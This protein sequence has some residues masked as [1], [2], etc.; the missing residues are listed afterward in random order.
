MRGFGGTGCQVIGEQVH[1]ETAED[2]R[3]C[4]EQPGS[5]ASW[6]QTTAAAGSMTASVLPVHNEG[7]L[8]YS[9]STGNATEATPSEEAL[10]WVRNDSRLRRRGW[11]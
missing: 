8:G 3:D 4:R 9:S 11:G 6:R 7:V 1:G 5:W 10:G 2:E